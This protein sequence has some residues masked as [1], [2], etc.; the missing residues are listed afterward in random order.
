MSLTNA[1]KLQLLHSIPGASAVWTRLNCGKPEIVVTVDTTTHDAKAARPQAFHSLPITYHPSKP[2]H[3]MEL[4]HP[5]SVSD[6]Y[7]EPIPGGVQIQPAGANWVGTL[8]AACQFRDAVGNRRWGILSNWHVMVSD[9][10]CPTCKIHQPSTQYPP[11]AQLSRWKE[12]NWVSPNYFDAALADAKIDGLHTITPYIRYIGR[13]DPVIAQ[14]AVGMNVCKVGRTTDTTCG[15][16]I[17]ID[18]AV[19]V[20]YERATATFLDQALFAS[21]PGSFSAPGDSGSLIL[22]VPRFQPVALLFAGNAEFT[23]GSPVAAIADYFGLSFQ[24]PN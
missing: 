2:F 16:C 7:N 4:R 8:G 15:Q 20:S 5:T 21:D 6:C 13:P 23:I 22:A 12:I 3:S 10:P 14:P 17:A 24:F 19:T 1:E 11:I 9:P 18:A